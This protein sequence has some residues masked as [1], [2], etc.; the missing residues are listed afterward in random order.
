MT[1]LAFLLFLLASAT[2]FA[3]QTPADEISARSGLPASEVSALLA[4][5]DS[6]QTSMN[7]C[8]WRDQIVAER[9]LQQV[10]D[11]QVSEHPERKAALEAKIAKW[12]KARD[13]SCEK[14]ARKEWGEG[15]MRP[16]AQAICVTASTKKMTK[17]LSSPD[18]K[19]ID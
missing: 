4:D 1:K 16:A 17:R 11:Q 18:R 13:A 9:E 19:A 6:N 7:F 10:V 15:S 3:E 12:K 5:C 8:A 2:A 14:S